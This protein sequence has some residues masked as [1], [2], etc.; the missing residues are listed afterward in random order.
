MK[1]VNLSE[2]I[3]IQD[4][5]ELSSKDLADKIAFD[6]PDN[7]AIVYQDVDLSDN[8]QEEIENALGE[9]GVY[10]DLHESML[11]AE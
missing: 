5:A 1:S 2:L 10:L 11:T 6:V 8:I 3:N 7:V 4:A 9:N